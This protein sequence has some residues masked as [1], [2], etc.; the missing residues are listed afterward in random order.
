[1]VRFFSLIFRHWKAY[2]P[3]VAKQIFGYPTPSPSRALSEQE[4]FL[5]IDPSSALASQIQFAFQIFMMIAYGTIKMSIVAFYR[6]LFVVHK[7]SPFAVIT[8]TI[9]VIILLW[10]IVFL[11]LVI[12]P[13]GEHVWATWSAPI[14]QIQF[15]DI[16]F[17][18]EYGLAMSDLILDIIVFLM[19]LPL[20]WSL[21]LATQRKLAVTGIMLLGAMAIGA[22][23]ARLIVYYQNLAATSSPTFPHRDENLGITTSLYWSFLE[24]GLAL[25][26][27]CLP[28]LS[29]LLTRQS[30][31]GSKLKSWRSAFSLRS[32]PSSSSSFPSNLDS[33][34]QARKSRTGHGTLSSQNHYRQGRNVGRVESQRGAPYAHLDSDVELDADVRGRMESR[35]LGRGHGIEKKTEIHMTTEKRAEQEGS[36]DGAWLNL[37]G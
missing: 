3:G 29:Y 8:M 36:S 24:C 2:V 13:C 25:I 32:S 18:S 10:T 27:A 14:Y 20:I 15:C 30:R 6:R 17:A 35:A 23:I 19:P 7:G 4:M 5:Y 31:I 9:W 16:A 34:S 11:F 26:A 12:F 33:D 1:M 21:Q 37:E 28:T 22:S